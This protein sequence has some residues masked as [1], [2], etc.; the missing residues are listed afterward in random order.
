M[1]LHGLTS[2]PFVLSSLW[3][4]CL[5][6][7]PSYV[8][9]IVH[10]FE[11]RRVQ[12]SSIQGLVAGIQFHLHRLDPSTD[13]LLENSSIHVLL[14]GEMERNLKATIFVSLSLSHWLWSFI[15]TYYKSS[16]QLFMDFSEMAESFDL[17]HDLTIADVTINFHYISIFLKHS[18]TD[19]DRK[20]MSM[21][22]LSPSPLLPIL[23]TL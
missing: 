5:S 18:K 11:S 7:F 13:I 12:P 19:G 3:L 14:N 20:G 21:A 8:P 22:C 16:S 9:F 23:R 17:S 15:W 2:S 6:V 1:I 4:F 10:S